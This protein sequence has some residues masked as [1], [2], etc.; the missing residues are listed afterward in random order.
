M[1]TGKGDLAS[2]PVNEGVMMDEPVV[3]E[4]DLLQAEVN[5]SEV[6]LLAVVT[7]FESDFDE[8]CY[9]ARFVS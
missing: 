6:D 2:G 3:T 1:A 5:Y 9:L 7:D 8:F 4:K